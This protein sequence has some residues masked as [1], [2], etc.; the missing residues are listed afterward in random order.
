MALFLFTKNI[1]EGKPLDVFNF[2]KME[3]DFTYVDD[4]VDGIMRA[5]DN[6]FPYE[7]F[8]LGNN[9]PIQLEYFI[10]VIEKELGIQ[11]KKNYMEIQPGDV[12]K[13]YAD[14]EKTKKMLGWEPTTSIEEGIKKFIEWYRWYYNV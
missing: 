12:P 10:S 1:V 13:T 6:Q 4:I 11:A 2:G 5:M 14:I 9:N 3:R 8:N 7:V